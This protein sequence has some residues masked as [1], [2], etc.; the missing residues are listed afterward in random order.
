I[1]GIG[2]AILVDTA[3]IDD[4]GELGQK[5]IAKTKA[6]LRTIDLAVLV[7]A[8]NDFGSFEENLIR[9]FGKFEVP[10]IIIH[11]KK[12]ILALDPE[13]E[14]KLKSEYATSVIDF[15][16]TFPDNL[17][18]VI[19]ALRSH[20]PETAY[21]AKSLLGDVISQGEVVLL[22]TPIDSE[23]PEGRMILPQVQAIRDILDNDAI[24]VVL[25]EN[26]LKNF[27]GK[28]QPRPAL[29]VTDSQV[30]KLVDEA[31]PKDI[32]I[33]SFSIMLARHKGDFEH[34]LDGT[35]KLGDLKNG[36][37]VL[38]LESCTHQVSC[39]DIG[40][41][42]IPGW[43]QKSTG[44]QLE[45]DVVAGLNNLPRDISEYAIVI[46]CGG[47]VITRKQIINRLKPAVDQ[48]IPVT[49]YGMAIAWLHGIF[50]R[51]VAVW[52]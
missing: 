40:R 37:R 46:Q 32:P 24:C 15:N 45:F 17:P 33:T 42:K 47:C 14:E 30:F 50:E 20:M 4:T 7:I 18:T 19:D 9:E 26:E 3:G 16:A 34:Y 29:V 6:V 36:D 31:V 22:V 35:R 44:K 10:F 2:P 13:L 11:N 12:D 51:S 8:G 49:N 5:R 38:I 43:L 21:T 1:F 25:K 52:K 39:D 27:I 23:A 48:G 28:M 41:V